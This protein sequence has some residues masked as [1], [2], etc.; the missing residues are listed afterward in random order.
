VLVF[1]E[2]AT[3]GASVGGLACCLCPPSLSF[4]L[5]SSFG[6]VEGRKNS[7]ENTSCC[8][9]VLGLLLGEDPAATSGG[10]TK[11]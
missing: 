10:S 6:L 1:L 5:P 11:I 4:F 7:S 9:A 2:E 8:E 3:V